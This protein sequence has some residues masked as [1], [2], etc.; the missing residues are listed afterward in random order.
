M[1]SYVDGHCDTIVKLAENGGS[2]LKNDTHI[3]IERMKLL[4]APVQVFALWLDPCYYAVALKKTMV[5]LEFYYS[6]LTKNRR[7]IAPVYRYGDILE[8]KQ[9]GKISAVLSIEGGEALEG[10][11]SL[12]SVYYRLGVRMMTLTWNHRNALADGVA[13]SQT[14]GGLTKFGKQ[15]MDRM[16]DMGMIVDVSHLSDQGFWDVQK[17]MKKPFIASHS[18]A[19]SICDVPRN[20]SDEALRAIAYSGGVVGLNLYP[21]FLAKNKEADMSDIWRHLDH[22]LEVAGED[23]VALGGDFDG[24][25]ALPKGIAGVEDYP[26]FL[27]CLQQRYGYKIAKKIAEENFLRVFQEVLTD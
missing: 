5:Y 25:D 20:L 1:I 8:N 9:N 18:N 19:R 7:E 13:E 10:E 22:M 3:D 17:R 12:L 15:V 6:E 24:V 27:I 4:G 2:L 26:N 16:Q 11:I 21:S 14:G 23:G